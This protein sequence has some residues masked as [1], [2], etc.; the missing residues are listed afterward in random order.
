LRSAE[1]RV[2]AAIASR[3]AAEQLYE[4]EQRQF[5]AG[6]TT[7]FLVLQRQDDLLQARSRELF[8]QTDLNKAISEFQR[9]TGTTLTANNVTVSDGRNFSMLPNRTTAFNGKFDLK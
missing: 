4:S 6:T 7:F 2:A 8:S 9:A 1:S 3:A 5:R